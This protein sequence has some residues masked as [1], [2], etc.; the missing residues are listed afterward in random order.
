[1]DTCQ[2]PNRSVLGS[3]SP[4]KYKYYNSSTLVTSSPNFEHYILQFSLGFFNLVRSSFCLIEFFFSVHPH[5]YFVCSSFFLASQT[6]LLPKVC[7]WEFPL[8][9]VCWQWILTNFVCKSSFKNIF[10]CIYNPR[11]SYFSLSIFQWER[12]FDD[13]FYCCWE[14]NCQDNY[15]PLKIFLI[16]LRSSLCFGVLQ[17]HVC[18]LQVWWISFIL[19]E[20]HEVS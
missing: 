14:D 20:I 15:H 4:S 1:M 19:H 11:L 7:S 8:V 9:R 6:S 13:V 2:N 10:C 17:F 5:I 18:Y 16:A 12:Y 3:S